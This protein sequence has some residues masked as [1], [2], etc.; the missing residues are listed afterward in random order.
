MADDIRSRAGLPPDQ[1]A[2]RRIRDGQARRAAQREAL[3]QDQFRQRVMEEMAQRR[4]AQQA[5]RLQMP[6]VSS[7]PAARPSMPAGR[8]MGAG[9]AALIG[10][11][12]MGAEMAISRLIEAS[13]GSARGEGD[14]YGLSERPAPQRQFAGEEMPFD[15][16]PAPA[17]VQAASPAPVRTV[18]AARVAPA[19]RPAPREELTADQLNDISLARARGEA[20]PV[21]GPSAALANARMAQREAEI[22]MAKG[23]YLGKPKKKMAMGGMPQ[24]GTAKAAP[25][26]PMKAPAK[27]PTP[28]M[29]KGGAMKGKKK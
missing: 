7:G 24:R 2:A 14:M 1:E 5:P 6:E 29:A 21:S 28:A 8:S 19:R 13:R 17:P 12:A 15:L 26:M 10:A 18:S 25:K 3:T 16:G 23:G 11:A 4:A 20:N 27:R 9:Q 22:G